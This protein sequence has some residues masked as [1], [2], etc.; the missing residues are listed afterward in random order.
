[1]NLIADTHTHTIASTHAYSTLT[2][3]VHAAAERG[4]YAIAIT[5]HGAEMPGSPGRW[6]FHNLK[7]VPRNLEGVLVLRGQEADVVNFEGD[8]DLYSRMLPVWIGWW[9]PCTSPLC[10]T[11]LQQWRR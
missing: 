11:R 2:E 10:G 9:H 8:T 4:L 1:M 6:Y 5:D 3:M 7:V